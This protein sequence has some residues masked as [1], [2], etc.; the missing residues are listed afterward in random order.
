[1]FVLPRKL[2]KL[3]CFNRRLCR[4]FTSLTFI[5]LL[6]YVLVS[7]QGKVLWE[8]YVR[9]SYIPGHELDGVN[10]RFEQN[11]VQQNPYQNDVNGFPLVD[12]NLKNVD[13]N[14]EQID[15]SRKPVNYSKEKLW[16][17]YRY[18][19]GQLG[20]S[21]VRADRDTLTRLNCT[22]KLP[23]VWIIGV[24]KCG[25]QMLSA[26]LDLHPDVVSSIYLGK[27]DVMLLNRTDFIETHMSFTTPSE[28]GL[29]DMVGLQNRYDTFRHVVGNIT[30][31]G[32]R[33]LLILIDPVKR[34]LSDYVHCKIKM[35]N[36]KN[37]GSYPIKHRLVWNVKSQRTSYEKVANFKGYNIATSFE[38]S[39]LNSSGEVDISNDL[40][41][42]GLYINYVSEILKFI[43]KEKLLIIDGKDFVSSPWDILSQTEI[44]LNISR[45]FSR[46]H[47]RKSGDYF[48]PVLRE[49]P[50]ADCL[51]GKGRPKPK[52]NSKVLRKLYNFYRPF[53]IK[54]KHM[55]NYEFSWM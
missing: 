20:L 4:I 2:R 8:N 45:F 18:K 46:K 19:E 28:V 39:V 27:S 21:R 22:R 6:G 9:A 13:T 14:R 5:C 12:Y 51:G 33:Y 31:H 34:A 7:D 40:I 49:R 17:C 29:F 53:N 26:L 54:L 41:N 32:T 24:K 48:C 52:V 50:D 11:N 1:M 15:E 16:G 3:S 10:S 47:F 43:P 37:I 25:S 38:K 42:K 36:V 23:G 44:F 35:K 30:T 55:T